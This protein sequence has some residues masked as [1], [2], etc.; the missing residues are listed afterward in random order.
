MKTILLHVQNDAGLEDRF[1]AALSLARA[2][3]AHLSC[4]QITPWQPFLFG[5][6]VSPETFDMVLRG[7]EE[8]ARKQRA[9]L[10]ARLANEEV[11]WDWLA[12]TTSDAIADIHRAAA[13]VDL[14][15]VGGGAT[16]GS[17]ASTLAGAIALY[18]KRPVLRVPAGVSAIDISGPIMIA[19]NG[20]Q[21]AANA[22]RN[23]LPLLRKA[24]SVHLVTVGEIVAAPSAEDA[25]RYLSRTGIHAEVHER[26]DMSSVEEALEAIAREIGATCIVMGAYGHSR[27]RELVFGGVTRHMLQGCPIPLLLSH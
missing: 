2:F 8:P 10:E 3:G 19:W 18:A 26:C 6:E 24:A 7:L 11:A 12:Y 23:S 1:Q 22:L 20:S 17:H 25:A 13:L 21:D 4:I 14:I 27:A 9:G 15:V 5:Q 16:E